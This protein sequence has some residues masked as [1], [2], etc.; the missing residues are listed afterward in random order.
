MEKML[1]EKAA[2]MRAAQKIYFRTRTATALSKSKSLE[3][4]FDNLYEVYKERQAKQ[5]E[6]F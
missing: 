4:A 6:L 2:E 5:P 3:R 1:I